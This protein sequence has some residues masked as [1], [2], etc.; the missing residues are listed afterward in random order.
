MYTSVLYDSS[1]DNARAPPPS[2]VGR[3][4]S[5]RGGGDGWED[6]QWWVEAVR[7]VMT[8][9][10]KDTNT[11]W[12]NKC[13]MAI[14]CG[15]CGSGSHNKEHQYSQWISCTDTVELYL[16]YLCVGGQTLYVTCKFSCWGFITDYLHNSGLLV[17]VADITVST[18]FINGLDF[19]RKY[20]IFIFY[21]VPLNCL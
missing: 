21:W 11:N 17:I 2:T 6:G 16:I 19:E 8:R 13:G 9:S 20:A 1:G 7:R 12:Q 14:V 10:N 18:Y 3:T 5:A 15:M 4:L